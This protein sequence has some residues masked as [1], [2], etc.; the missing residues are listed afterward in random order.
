MGGL[1]IF[2]TPVRNEVRIMDLNILRNS[3]C[4]C[5]NAYDKASQRE[6]CYVKESLSYVVHSDAPRITRAELRRIG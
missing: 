5:Q 3:P 4:L 2:T 1:V 6:D